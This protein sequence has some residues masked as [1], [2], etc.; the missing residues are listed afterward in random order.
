MHLFSPQRASYIQKTRSGK[1]AWLHARKQCNME[2]SNN[3][4]IA[5]LEHSS[6][7]EWEENV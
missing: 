3:F 6:Y 1:L 7:L 5:Q 2:D 4:N